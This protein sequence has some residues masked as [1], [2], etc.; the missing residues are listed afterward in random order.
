[1]VRFMR[2]STIQSFVCLVAIAFITPTQAEVA[3]PAV[4]ASLLTPEDKLI[5]MEQFEKLAPGAKVTRTDGPEGMVRYTAEW[6]DA[7]V[8]LN[9][10]PEYD[11]ETQNDGALGF[12]SRFP[13]EDRK[14]HESK[15]LVD[16]IPSVRQAYGIV[17]PRG[18]DGKGH[19][20][21]LLR[22]LAKEL[23]GYLISNSSF[24][25]PRGFRI[26][27]HPIDSP[28]LGLAGRNLSYLEK[29]VPTKELLPGSWDVT[30]GLKN[31]D[32]EGTMQVWLESVDVFG[33]DG[34]H[35]SKGTM[36][37][38]I[39]PPDSEDGF[40]M[41]FD[42][43]TT[44]R[45]EEKEG[46]VVVHADKATT[47]NHQAEIEELKEV[48]EEM[49]AE[50]RKTTEPDRNWLIALDR[51]RVLFEESEAGVTGQMTRRIPPDAP[52]PPAKEK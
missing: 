33:E 24:Y 5:S 46:R 42:F 21:A 32:A 2:L 27:G 40:T 44:G 43:E 10:K 17:L 38:E 16:F 20:S 26:L 18:F 51:D 19:A 29:P 31:V 4:K 28:F 37:I 8:N 49:A 23:D 47:A 30:F 13:E 25:D 45:W 11:H 12:I 41:S 48:L 39:T 3:I 22:N 7:T 9:F 1:M 50:M 15:E 35:H 36:E 52:K 34:S 6:P 14:T